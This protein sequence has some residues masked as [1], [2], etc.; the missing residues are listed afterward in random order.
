VTDLS[1]RKHRVP[2][3]RRSANCRRSRDRETHL[4]FSCARL[5]REVSWLTVESRLTETSNRRL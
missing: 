1:P 4:A 2:P 3:R 5:Q